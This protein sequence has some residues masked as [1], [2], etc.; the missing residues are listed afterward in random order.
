MGQFGAYHRQHKTLRLATGEELTVYRVKT[1]TFSDG[2]PPALQ[3]EYELPSSVSDTDAVRRYGR[4]AWPVFD[5]YLEKRGFQSAIVTATNLRRT[6]SG[7]AWSSTQQ[8]FGLVADRNSSGRWHFE[9]DPNALPP[10]DTASNAGI[11]EYSGAPL[12]PSQILPP[13]K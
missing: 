9:G 1:W 10:A 5:R 4:L 13:Q 11:Y 12:L 8:S 2:A 6:D 3:L 7:P